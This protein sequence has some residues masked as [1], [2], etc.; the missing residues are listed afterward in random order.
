MTPQPQHIPT[1]LLRVPDVLARVG[2]SRSTWYSW[3]REGG[4]D[5][6]PD[7]P[8]SVKVGA[9]AVAWVSSEVEEFI[10]KKIEKSRR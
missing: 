4:K 9:K 2:V 8:K 7:C 5:F 3:Q 6:D 1:E 10:V